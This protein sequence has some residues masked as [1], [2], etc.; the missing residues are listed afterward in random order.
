MRVR[1]LH[2]SPFLVFVQDPVSEFL[3]FSRQPLFL[4]IGKT[5]TA[6]QSLIFDSHPNAGN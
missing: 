3:R 4:D 5:D 2:R 6:Q 1:S